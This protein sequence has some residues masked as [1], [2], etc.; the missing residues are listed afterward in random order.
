MS[1]PDRP[2]GPSPRGPKPVADLVVE[3]MKPAARKRG[4]ATVDL[5]AYWADIVGQAYADCTRPE[6]L[7]WPKRLEDGG[8]QGFEPATLT[9]ACEGSRALL[10]QHEAAEIARRINAVFGFQAVG[11]IRI[12][13]KPLSRIDVPRAPRL[14]ELTPAESR[15]LSGSL[16]G[17]E[18]DG[19]KAALERLGRAVLAS[20]KT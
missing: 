6:K 16:D 8:E 17:I 3:L 4:F 1:N 15:R 13:Q 11:R 9:V 12:V 20:R 19:L 2:P 18:D 5:V 14:R 10:F 7:S